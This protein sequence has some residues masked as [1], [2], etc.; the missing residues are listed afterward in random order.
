MKYI[1]TS[2]IVVLIL[3]L[4]I[5]L[6]SSCD[7]IADSKLETGTIRGTVKTY[8]GDTL[9]AGAIISTNP[10]T[11]VVST[12]NNGEYIIENVPIGKY[13]VIANKQGFKKDSLNVNVIKDKVSL[14]E[15]RLLRE[16]QVATGEL[17]AYYPFNGNVN[18]ESGNNYHGT[19][20]NAS[21]TTDRFN[22]PNKAFYF[23]GNSFIELN[24]TRQLNF[25]N[26]TFTICAWIKFNEYNEDNAIVFKH[27]Y[28]HGTGYGLGVKNNKI[29]FYISQDPRLVTDETYSDN[30]WHFI[31]GILDGNIQKLY[32]D[33]IL[34]KT[35]V[36]QYNRI[37]NDVNITIGNS[38]KYQGGYGG[39]FKGSIDDV[40]IFNKVL[41]H[42][43]IQSL[44]L[45]EGYIPP[46]AVNSTIV[47]T[48]KI[49][50]QTD[51]WKI[52]PDGTGRANLINWPSSNEKRPVLSPNGD[53]LA[54]ISNKSG[55][56]QI[57]VANYDGS[58]PKQI[59]FDEEVHTG[60]EWSP[61]GQWLYYAVSITHINTDIYKVKVDGT[62]RIAIKNGPT[63]EYLPIVDPIYGRY[64]IY[65]FDTGAWGPTAIWKK[66]DMLT[67]QEITLVDC[68]D[69][70]KYG[71][72]ELCFSP[73][74]Q[75]LAFVRDIGSGYPSYGG[76]SNV[77]IM[78]SDGSNWVKLTNLTGYGQ[79]YRHPTWSPDGKFLV[80]SYDY[81]MDRFHDYFYIINVETLD[82]RKLDIG[83]GGEAYE[84]YWGKI[85]Q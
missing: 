82:L 26:N 49:N 8:Y 31:V 25:N 79:L 14:A 81:P 30:R 19:N 85:L 75:K 23:S 59:T 78:N 9:L 39:Y 38:Y 3:I 83:L 20:N 6:F 74:G 51:I 52:N 5:C 17:I 65:K 4:T 77:Y 37:H 58:N 36:F 42:A 47:F 57:W 28:F 13:T 72:H 84:P 53:K 22:R 68:T 50:N 11:S 41:S 29:Y 73:D 56:Y 43:E 10:A 1:K 62:Q 80:F 44:Y 55:K 35:Q 54:F 69:P 12:N 48:Y 33:G 34:K 66:L 64:L 76:P 60:P 67:G 16:T 32:V 21:L 45:E 61:D 24:N 15:F 18:D 40:R 70:N 2:L 7:K 63:Y 46:S 27:L 71:V